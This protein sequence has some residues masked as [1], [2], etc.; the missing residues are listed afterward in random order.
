MHDY[1]I[2]GAGSAGCVLASRLSEDPSARVLVL[3][4]GPTDHKRE[5]RIPAAWTKLFRSEVDWNFTTVP[6]EGLRGRSVFWPRGKTLGGSSSTNAMMAILGHAA[7]FDGWAARAGES[8]SFRGVAPALRRV[9]ETLEIE[10]LRDPNPLT[11]AF[12]EA[13]AQAGIPRASTLGPTDLDG[14]RLSPVTQRRGRR[15]SAADAYLRPALDRPNLSVLTEAHA[16]RVLVDDGRATGVAYRRKGHEEVARCAREVVLCGGVVGSPQL[17][18]LSG[19]GPAEHLAEQGIGLVHA[20]PGVGENLQDHVASG[21][22]VESRAPVTLFAAE[23]L[24]NLLRYLLLRRGMLTSNV[25]EAAA[26]VHSR[27]GLPAPDLE[28]IFCPALFEQ[29]GLAPPRG[30]GFTIASVALQPRSR[31]VVRLTSPD[32]FAKPLI[33]PSYLSDPEGE[34]RRVLVA[35]LELA[36]AIGGMPALARFAGAELAPGATPLPEHVSYDAQGLYHAVGTCHMGRDDLAV[37]DP[38]LRVRGLE[39]LRVVDASVLPCLPRGHTNLATMVVAERAAELM[40][41]PRPGRPM[42]AVKRHPNRGRHAAD[43][44]EAHGA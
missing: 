17:L 23:T 29:E 40:R 21:L 38:E 19:I 8:W 11:L 25:A 20:L 15:W 36:R 9:L 44:V 34:D 10:E 43:G 18:L 16:T 5:I 13:A 12:L 6:Q 35:G 22:L 33:D 39:G 7:D 42:R 3:E 41:R 24:G 37:V 2:V 32:P 14:A 27:A 1:V 4:A 26:F 30:H 28:L 31:G